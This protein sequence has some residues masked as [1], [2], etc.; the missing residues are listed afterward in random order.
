MT[1][2][3][4]NTK[5]P[6]PELRLTFQGSIPFEDATL[7][8]IWY[9]MLKEMVLSQSPKSTLNGQIMKM[10]EPCCGDKTKTQLSTGVQMVRP[11]GVRLT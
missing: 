5:N 3:Q 1:E 10:L 6:A 7:A 9:N 4:N 2:P 11:G 8:T